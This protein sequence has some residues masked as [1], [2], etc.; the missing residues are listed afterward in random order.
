M[1]LEPDD[2]ILTGTPPGISHVRPGDRMRIEIDGLGALENVLTSPPRD[3]AAP[4][5]PAPQSPADA[6]PTGQQLI[7]GLRARPQEIWIGNER[8]RDL[9]QHPAFRNV[10]RSLA[11][12][13][14]MQHDPEHWDDMTYVSPRRGERGR[15]LVH[16]PR[17]RDDLVRGRAMISGG[18][19]SPA[20]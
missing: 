7:D 4:A 12:L 14:D 16:Q 18:R 5:K 11:A 9:T 3:Q 15:A 19:T 8:V 1:T 10:I 17:T 20:A 13:Y 6:G 2:V